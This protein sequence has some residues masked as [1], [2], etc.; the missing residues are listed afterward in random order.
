[1]IE[2][3]PRFFLKV[4]AGLFSRCP[5][6]AQESAA[7]AMWRDAMVQFGKDPDK[8]VS[9][10]PARVEAKRASKW[11]MDAHLLVVRRGPGD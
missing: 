3:F 5:M 6:P 10:A 9:E 11:M 7:A 8:L 2:P 1:M 4:P